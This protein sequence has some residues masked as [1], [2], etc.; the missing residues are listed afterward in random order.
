MECI[1]R[2]SV[3]N[4][5][6]TPRRFTLTNQT[7]SKYRGFVSRRLLKP[8]EGGNFTAV[9]EFE[10]QASFQ[11]MHS[12]SAHDK[13]GEQVIPFFNWTP[14]PSFYDVISE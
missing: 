11:A 5:M 10:N 1:V 13:A 4:H 14:T 3:D 2:I 12:N 7:F 9:V 8:L 6:N